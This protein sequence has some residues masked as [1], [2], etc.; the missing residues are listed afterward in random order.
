MT[1]FIGFCI[2]IV[3]LGLILMALDDDDFTPA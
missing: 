1:V 2:A 3:F